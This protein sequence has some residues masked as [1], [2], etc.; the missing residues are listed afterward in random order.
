MFHDV[1]DL[2]DFYQG[3]LGRVVQ[4][5]I[6]RELRQLWPDVRRQRLLGVGYVTPYLE[7][8]REEAERTLAFMPAQQGVLH[9]PE[10]A[11]NGAAL[12]D[13]GS[14][15]LP[16]YSVDRVVLVHSLEHTEQLRP[17]LQEVWRVMMG[18]AR[19]MVVVPNRRSLW[20]RMERT[21][22][23][24]GHPFTPGQL[25]RLMKEQNFVPAAS[26]AALFVP[27]THSRTLLGAAPAWERL[28]KR[29]LPQFSGLVMLEATKQVY[30]STRPLEA[31]RKRRAAVAPMPAAARP[32]GMRR[33]S[34]DLDEAV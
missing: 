8:F 22:L 32:A 25:T 12:V 27:P 23:G 18:D 16:D 21:P 6:Q 33:E 7:P 20:S 30:A 19:L 26:R 3:R 14:L 5:T 29:W 13:E 34:A 4:Q 28:G 15:P 17:L 10:R 11:R 31:E 1:V 9:W 24:H 2:Q